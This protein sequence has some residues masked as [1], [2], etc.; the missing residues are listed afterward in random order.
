MCGIVGMISKWNSNGFL[1]QEQKLMYE[2]LYADTLRG[3]DATG[4]IAVHNDGDFS[5]MKKAV[6][7]PQFLGEYIKSDVDKEVYKK[8]KAFIAH[9][10]AKTVGENKDENAHPFVVDD[11]FAMVHNGTLS[12]HKS[13]KDTSVDSEALAHVFKEAMDQEDWKEAMEEALGKVSGAFACVWYDQK[14]NQICMI[15]NSQRPLSYLTTGQLVVFGSEVKMLEWLCVRNNF[16]ITAVK[17]F[18]P[19]TLYQWDLNKKVGGEFSETFLSPKKTTQVIKQGYSNGTNNSGGTRTTTTTEHSKVFSST[20]L[21]LEGV[22][23]VSKNLFKRLCRELQNKF[24]KFY[25][26]DYIEN[27]ITD[28]SKATKA[29]LIGYVLDYRFDLT[30]V[31]HS[32][33]GMVNLDS[34]ITL[35]KLNDA[36]QMSGKMTSFEYDKTNKA[37]IIHVTGVKI[38]KTD[39]K[40]LH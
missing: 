26:E 4:V 22:T 27:N 6:P 16:N 31:R 3:Y 20:S 25:L 18:K 15:R 5:I 28:P 12:N 13:L 21:N 32:I 35:D 34:T 33:Q 14:R 40:V 19:H 7:A 10:R 39:E 2:L 8:G 29:K 38:E 36:T 9:N 11:T 37:I 1:T 23:T 30:E 24:V 17:E